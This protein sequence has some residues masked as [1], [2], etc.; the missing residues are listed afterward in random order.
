MKKA[1]H[2]TIL[3]NNTKDCEKAN[4]TAIEIVTREAVIIIII[5]IMSRC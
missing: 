1:Y 5:I 2:I 3:K 4:V